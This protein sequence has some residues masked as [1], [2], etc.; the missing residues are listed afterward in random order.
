MGLYV[1]RSPSHAA[2][3]TLIFNPRTGHVSP[4]FHIIF[5]D[6]FTT[7]PYLGSSQVPPF[8]VDLVCASTK[9]HSYI[10]RQVEAWQ[11][12]PELTPEIGDF[13]S[14]QTEIPNVE[15]GTSANK[16]PASSLKGSK[17]VLDASMSEHK[18]WLQV[19]SFHDQNASGD[20]NPQPNEW[21]MPESVDLHK[22]GL[23]C[24]SC[25]AAL[26]SNET[27]AA[28]STLPIKHTPYKVAC[29]ALFSSFCSFGMG[30]IALV[31]THQTIAAQMP[32]LLTTAVNCFH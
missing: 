14:E 18:S 5:D 10:K 24:S 23:R 20:N 8:W 4:Q 30:L 27:I 17:E 31:H 32:S 21:A 26:H 9:L 1:G 11:S 7:V 12:L 29:L 15:L 13:T 19:V 2:N 28:H 22:S 6:D 25:L 16:V 3:V